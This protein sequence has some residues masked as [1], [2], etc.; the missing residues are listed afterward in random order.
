MFIS[1]IKV[2]LQF[3]LDNEANDDEW[4]KDDEN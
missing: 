4:N 2:L 1:S 3:H